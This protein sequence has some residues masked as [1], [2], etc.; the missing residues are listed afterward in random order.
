MQRTAPGHSRPGWGGP[1]TWPKAP[2]ATSRTPLQGVQPCTQPARQGTVRPDSGRFSGCAEFTETDRSTDGP[3]D[4]CR[5]FPAG[6][7]KARRLAVMLFTLEEQPCDLPDSGTWR[8]S[9]S[10]VS[11]ALDG[12]P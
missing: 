1:E 4:E 11:R 8:S 12:D 6:S 10:L 9:P 2:A 5:L 3:S 7:E